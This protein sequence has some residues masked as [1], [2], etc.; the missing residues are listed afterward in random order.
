MSHVTHKDVVMDTTELARGVVRLSRV[1]GATRLADGEQAANDAAK[2][3][4]LPP[5][6]R[7][8]SLLLAILPVTLIAYN[9]FNRSKRGTR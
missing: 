5:A 7:V 4:L 3:S 6:G 9:I 1:F 2:A 8:L